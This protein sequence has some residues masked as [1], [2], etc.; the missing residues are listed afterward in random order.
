MPSKAHTVAQL[1]QDILALQ[2]FKPPPV[3]VT[4]DVILGSIL[5]AFPNAVFPR[6]GVHEFTC[7]SAEEAAASSGFVSGLISSLSKKVTSLVWIASSPPIFP[8]ALKFFGLRPEQI[9]FLRVRKEADACWAVEEALKCTSL[10]AVVSEIKD[11]SFTASRR[12]QLAIEKSGV[13]CFLLRRNPR[14]ATTAC[15]TRW[16]IKPLPTQTLD[17]LPGVGRP[18]WQVNLLKVRNGKPGSWEIEW[19]KGQFRY[20]PKL[21]FIE[22]RLQTKTG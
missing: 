15:L 21:A 16:R 14:N 13:G 3:G 12:F 7:E 18:R 4:D 5:H 9:V 2:G 17:D 6:T 19:V 20:A 11:I 8:L 1:Q 10:T 22:G